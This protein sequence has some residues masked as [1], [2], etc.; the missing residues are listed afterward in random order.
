MANGS[1]ISFNIGCIDFATHRGCSQNFVDFVWV[2][3]DNLSGHFD[4]SISLVLF[5][6]LNIEQVLWRNKA[7]VRWSAWT[8]LTGRVFDLPI[9][10][11]YCVG[12]LIQLIG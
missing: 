12:V 10:L 4:Y 8:R 11:E 3:K 7:R 2:T 9:N 6:D 1:I 5:D